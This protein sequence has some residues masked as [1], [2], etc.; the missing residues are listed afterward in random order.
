MLLGQIRF[1][2]RELRELKVREEQGRV[3]ATLCEGCKSLLHLL[4]EL[5]VKIILSYTEA[6]TGSVRLQ[7]R[8]QE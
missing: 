6:R 7:R 2:R 8:E 1:V 5:K 4:R 3:E